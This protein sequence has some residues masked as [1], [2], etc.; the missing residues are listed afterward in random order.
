MGWWANSQS[1]FVIA[2]EFSI[3]AK[4]GPSLGKVRASSSKVRAKF[5]P[6]LGQVWAKFGPSLGKVWAKFG[7]SL[8]KVWAKFGQSL[9]QV[10]AKFGPSLGKVWAKFGQ[11]LGQV[12]AKFGPSSGKVRAKF[13]QSSGQVRAKFGPSSGKVRA[14]FGQSS[15]QV[16]AKSEDDIRRRASMCNS[17]TPEYFLLVRRSDL[18]LDILTFWIILNMKKLLKKLIISAWVI[19]PKESNI[20]NFLDVNFFKQKF[21]T[22]DLS[23]LSVVQYSLNSNGMWLNLAKF[24]RLMNKHVYKC[25]GGKRGNTHTWM[26]S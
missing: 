15:G 6:S 10:R 24:G 2:V 23:R 3:W 20:L 25:R 5:G 8:G 18:C 11:S 9:G 13:G 22:S 17:Y 14:K 16:R 21:E 7:Q 12:R 19:N 26:E 1:D 4:F